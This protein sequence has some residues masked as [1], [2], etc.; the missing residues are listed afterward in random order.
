MLWFS[1]GKGNEPLTKRRWNLPHR[2]LR[3]RPREWVR[4][5]GA[6]PCASI[7][8]PKPSVEPFVSVF[9]FP[10]SKSATFAFTAE[11][12]ALSF[13]LHST[14]AMVHVFPCP[15]D[16]A[17]EV[18]FEGRKPA[19]RKVISVATCLHSQ[20]HH[21]HFASDL[22][23]YFVPW[24][25]SNSRDLGS[26]LNLDSEPRRQR[27]FGPSPVDFLEPPPGSHPHPPAWPLRHTRD[28]TCTPPVWGKCL[29][30]HRKLNM[31]CNKERR[32]SR[33]VARF[34]RS[35]HVNMRFVLV[36]LTASVVTRKN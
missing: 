13:G 34:R 18:P 23:T 1:L 17:L 22:A 33:P 15:K 35:G 3:L 14:R 8:R 7:A 31:M 28:I 9:S 10:W 20:S 26:Q 2:Q 12:L 11:S 30:G 36:R 4:T 29:S 24:E 25:Q 16:V 32:N 21:E 27:T 19:H 6:S 5:S